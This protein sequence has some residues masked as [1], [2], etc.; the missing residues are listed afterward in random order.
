MKSNALPL[1]S[2]TGPQ[3]SAVKKGQAPSSEQ[4]KSV[5]AER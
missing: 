2:L 3:L 1:S 4:I 5:K